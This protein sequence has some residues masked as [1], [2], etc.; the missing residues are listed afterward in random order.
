[1]RRSLATENGECFVGHLADVETVAKRKPMLNKAARA[2]RLV[3]SVLDPR[4]WA[5]VLLLVNYYNY[6]HVAP[7]RQIKVG[8]GAAISPNAVFANAQR[9]QIGRN[10]RIGARC[11]LW[12]GP[13]EGRIIIGDDVMF[14]PEVMLT[15]STYRYNEGH[16]VTQQPLEEAD[17]VIGNDVW[18]GARAIVLPGARIGDG[19]IIGAAA[20]VRGE[21]PPMSVAV[22]APAK[23][24]A[25]RET[26]GGGKPIVNE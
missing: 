18:L 13:H 2:W 26:V 9:I 15:A 5:H 24:V 4:A 6:V 16:P 8:S 1:M 22:G 25:E 19:A 11:Y 12:A 10:C 3:R 21:I 20:I 17:I 23:V 14:G 7:R